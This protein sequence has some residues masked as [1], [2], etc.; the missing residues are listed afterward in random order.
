MSRLI[1][2][3]T[4]FGP[5]VELIVGENAEVFTF[6]ENILCSIAPYFETALRGGYKETTAKRIEMLDENPVVIRRF[7]LWVYSGSFFVDEA[8]RRSI[9]YTLCVRIYVFAECRG[10]PLLQDNVIDT[11]VSKYL[12][13]ED[14]ATM[15]MWTIINDIYENTK[16]G[17]PIRRYF[18]DITQYHVNGGEW[19]ECV[20]PEI[21][22]KDFFVDMTFAL[23]SSKMGSAPTVVPTKNACNYHV[24]PG[25]TSKP[26]SDAEWRNGKKE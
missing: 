1:S 5:T 21:L 3:S 6:Y 4:S 23:M 22:P 13:R 24:H 25:S 19:K 11:C 10:I 9:D 18:V 16:E 15:P 12:D 14:G 7:Q 26:K 17:S 20:C 2:Y 8:D